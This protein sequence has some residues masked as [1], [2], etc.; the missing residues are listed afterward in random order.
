LKRG[1][2]ENERWEANHESLESCGWNCLRRNRNGRAGGRNSTASSRESS[3]HLAD[4]DNL[5]IE[6][7]CR[8]TFV[9]SRTRIHSIVSRDFAVYEVGSCSRISRTSFAIYYGFLTSDI[10]CND[11]ASHES[12]C[13]AANVI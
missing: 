4:S 5:G 9:Y 11:R 7:P 12:V 13:W 3:W 6:R 1:R 2:L 8:T 10:A